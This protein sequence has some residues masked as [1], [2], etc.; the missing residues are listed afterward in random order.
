MKKPIFAAIACL[1]L[2]PVIP[3]CDS[4][5]WEDSEDGKIKGTKHLYEPHGGGHEGGH[6]EDGADH[7]KDGGH[8][9]AD[10]AGHG[11]E[12]DKDHADK[13]NTDKG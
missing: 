13:E 8:D 3:A 10:K 7:S 6:D 11:H 1:A 9:D 4:H 2:I 5:T 12:G